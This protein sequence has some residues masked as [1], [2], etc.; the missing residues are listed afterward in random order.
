MSS[1]KYGI[2]PTLC[3][4]FSLTDTGHT[5]IAEYKSTYF[6]H[7]AIYTSYLITF[8]PIAQVCYKCMRHY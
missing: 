7:S 6:S 1:G 5:V 3:L 4:M 2:E 8:K